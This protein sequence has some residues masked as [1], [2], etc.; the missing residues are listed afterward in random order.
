M[1]F[2]F[3]G[4]SP[5]YEV[6]DGVPEACDLFSLSV[7][8]LFWIRTMLLAPEANSVFLFGGCSPWYEDD[9]VALE[10]NSVFPFLWVL[11]LV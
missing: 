3:C 4:C 11:S 7:G 8:A 1:S 6:G 10:A 9:V 5:L 2:P